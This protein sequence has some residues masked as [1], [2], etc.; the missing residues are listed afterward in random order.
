MTRIDKEIAK[1]ARQPRETVI[2]DR[3]TYLRGEI[4]RLVAKACAG[5]ATQDDADMCADYT[6]ELAE[7]EG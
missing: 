4:D 2:S 5:T 1:V 6:H 3:V 7:L